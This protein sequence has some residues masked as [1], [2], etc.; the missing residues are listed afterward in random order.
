MQS[1]IKDAKL[2]SSHIYFT[3]IELYEYIL[4]G[5]HKQAWVYTDLEPYQD[6]QTAINIIMQRMK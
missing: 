3:L 4:S 1:H 6:I 2:K 5:K